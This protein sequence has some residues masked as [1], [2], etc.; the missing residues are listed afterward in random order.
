MIH[1]GLHSE[2]T[3]KDCYGH[4]EKMVEARANKGET[5]VGI[6]DFNNTYSHIK[7]K[8]YCKEHGVKPI[9]GVRLMVTDTVTKGRSARQSCEHMSEFTF[10]AK[11]D[12]GLAEIYKLVATAY[13]NFYYMPRLSYDDVIC[14]SK[15]VFVIAYYVAPNK[16]LAYHR[17]DFLGES[18][19]GRI[20]L[21]R[22]FRFARE[23]GSLQKKPY[24]MLLDN[25]FTDMEDKG[26]Y[27][28]LSYPKG[29]L[30]PG[31]QWV[32]SEKEALSS[33]I[34]QEAIIIL[35]YWQSNA[36]RISQMHR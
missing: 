2:F 30:I 25:K 22:S 9:Y 4:L 31:S 23:N 36:T 35:I 13:S 18:I 6:A 17:L 32:L 24:I 10:I 27:E 26:V 15:N 3:F 7:L 21:D 29:N 16:L 1:I 34:T 5:H 19:S 8:K 12:A 28:M 14:V 11:N 20:P 33:G